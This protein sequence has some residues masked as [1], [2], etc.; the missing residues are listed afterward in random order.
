MAEKEMCCGGHHGGLLSKIG[1]LAVVYGV[2]QYLMVAQAWPVYSSWIAGG[3]LLIL[4][5]WAKKN[6]MK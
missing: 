4:V 1:I 3:V 6:M 5:G 2:T